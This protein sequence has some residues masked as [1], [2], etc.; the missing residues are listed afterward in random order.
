M[1]WSLRRAPDVA[2]PFPVEL[3]QAFR[4]VVVGLVAILVLSLAR[5]GVVGVVDAR[6]ARLFQAETALDTIQAAMVD[7][8]SRLREHVWSGSDASLEAYDSLGERL[9]PAQGT[10]LATLAGDAE[11]GPLVLAMFDAQQHWEH[12][13]A[14]DVRT[15]PAPVGGPEL[16][17]VLGDGRRYFDAYRRTADAVDHALDV[18]IAATLDGERTLFWGGIVLLVLLGGWLL[19]SL[20]AQFHR[21]QRRVAVPLTEL[22]GAI[23]RVRAGDLDVDATSDGPSE[24]AAMAY[25][26]SA[27][28][29]ALAAERQRADLREAELER[30]VELAGRVLELARD[31][32]ATMDLPSVVESVARGSLPLSGMESARLWLVSEDRERL[33]LAFVATSDGVGDRVRAVGTSIRFGEALAGRTAQHGRTMVAL[34]SAS[35]LSVNTEDACD[36]VAL[37][38]IAGGECLGVLELGASAPM[39]IEPAL[40]QILETLTTQAGIAVAAS[41]LHTAAEEQ[42]RRDP[43]TGLFNR[44][45]MDA[46]LDAE[47][48]R[49]TRY[50][51]PCSFMLLDI[52]HFKKL[53]DTYGHTYG[54]EVLREVA[55]LL[56]ASLRD[57]DTA[58]RYG[59][60]EFAVVLR[61]TALDDALPLVERLRCDVERHF[62]GRRGAPVTA[63]FGAAGVDSGGDTPLRVIQA[64]DAA[65]Y[66]AKERG[67]NRLE[68]APAAAPVAA[69]P[70][71]AI[72][73]AEVR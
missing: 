72:R 19:L 27:T 41:R 30:H 12:G 24:L 53:N 69:V 43:L 34:E 42:G 52:D 15:R 21:L 60:E 61:A 64:A 32:T 17:S 45:Q 56:S 6:K 44:R 50:G 49:A 33:D 4:P 18:R 67:R 9:L 2:T 8:D 40:L 55:G 54:D 63:S 7:Q 66:R 51:S 22:L 48:R 70:P 47:S 28:A 57:T 16:E 71:P 29:R 20:R 5:F 3:A 23:R 1:K 31:F 36:A 35:L 37:P 13:W 59:G 58:Y 10:L 46:D 65:L 73:L 62:A 26:L 68:A 39:A 25:E 38:M 11:L 14:E